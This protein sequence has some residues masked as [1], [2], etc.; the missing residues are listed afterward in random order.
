MASITACPTCAANPSATRMTPSEKRSDES[1]ARVIG[2]GG[3]RAAGL[4]TGRRP[5]GD[6][7]R[8]DLEDEAAVRAGVDERR[9]AEAAHRADDRE[10]VAAALAADRPRRVDQPVAP[11][12]GQADRVDRLAAGADLGDAR[13]LLEGRPSSA[14]CGS[15]RSA[16]PRARKVRN[17]TD[18]AEQ[19][20]DRQQAD[21]AAPV[22][23]HED[24]RDVEDLG[25]DLVER[26]R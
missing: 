18:Q 21:E 2:S 25:P 5:D 15:G 3:R 14:A 1:A 7:P 9:A 24:R 19:D 20:D 8:L 22:G 17:G 16:I 12:V 11:A 4:G 13:A 23:H 26:R 10:L 6:G